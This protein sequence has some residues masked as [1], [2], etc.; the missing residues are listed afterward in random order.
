MWRAVLGQF[1]VDWVWG[2][3]WQQISVI[4]FS[5][6]M[7]LVQIVLLNMLIALMREIYNKVRG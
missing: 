7:F 4:I 5:G 2:S 1:N 6:F 3:A